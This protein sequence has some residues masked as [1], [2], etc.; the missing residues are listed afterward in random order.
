MDY[1][2][3]QGPG[4]SMEVPTDWFISSSVQS[5]VIVLAPPTETGARP[6]LAVSM[7]PVRPDVTV[8][9]IAEEARTLQVQEYPGYE[10]LSERDFSD[11]GGSAFQRVYQ[12]QRESTGEPL[13]QIQ[14][15]IVA[16]QMLFTIT[17]TRFASEA[18]ADELDAAFAHM[19]ASFRVEVRLVPAE[20]ED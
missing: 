19:V 6:N 17:G 11:D 20:D 10:V 18:N 9:A 3:F 13:V 1:K 14:T 7:T 8:T 15:F 5:Q 12:W 4:F 2:H 16:G